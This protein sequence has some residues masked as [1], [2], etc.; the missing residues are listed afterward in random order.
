MRNQFTPQLWWWCQDA[1]A[2]C[3]NLSFDSAPTLRR[4]RKWLESP[5]RGRCYLGGGWEGRRRSS[6]GV[7]EE[8][9]W[10]S[11]VLPW[12]LRS[13]QGVSTEPLGGFDSAGRAVIQM[14]SPV[15]TSQ[16]LAATR[17]IRAIP[18]VLLARRDFR[19]RVG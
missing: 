5:A 4:S 7:P 11:V 1:P 9:A 14:E 12:G 2:R 3:H 6:E 17:E 15:S 10:V 16:C 18:G 13:L 8:F 19:F